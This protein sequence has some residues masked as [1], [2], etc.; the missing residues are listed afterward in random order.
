MAVY[1]WCNHLP[2]PNVW[3]LVWGRMNSLYQNISWVAWTFLSGI[4]F[5][6]RNCLS[7][8]PLLSCK[9]WYLIANLILQ[10]L[11][12]GCSIWMAYLHQG[13]FGFQESC[14]THVENDFFI[15]YHLTTALFIFQCF[16]DSASL[17]LFMC[18]MDA[19]VSSPDVDYSYL[20]QSLPTLFTE[21]RI[22]KTQTLSWEFWFLLSKGWHNR[23]FLFQTDFCM[24]V[25]DLNSIPHPFLSRVLLL[26]SSILD[27]CTIS[28]PPYLH[29]HIS[30]QSLQNF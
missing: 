10:S 24:F 16:T 18:S 9:A 2:L 6:F 4:T 20:P 11:K 27:S 26:F 5:S 13:S 29:C 1:G 12:R 22:H 8:V 7:H 19:C 21:M 3:N 25:V 14:I 17:L 23:N 28:I 15:S 30:V